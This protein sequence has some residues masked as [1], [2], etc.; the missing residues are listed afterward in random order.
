MEEK[1][2][3]KIFMIGMSMLLIL[4]LVIGGTYAWFTLQL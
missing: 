2:K 1:S 3:K 4:V